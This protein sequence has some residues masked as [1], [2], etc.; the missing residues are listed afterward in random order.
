MIKFDVVGLFELV[1][2]DNETVYPLVVNLAY[3]WSSARKESDV[4]PQEDLFSQPLGRLLVHIECF[5]L[6]SPVD[7]L[8]IV[9]FALCLEDGDDDIG[10]CV[11]AADYQRLDADIF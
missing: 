8:D 10:S 5:R 4:A 9:H 2:P 11:A 6:V 1:D 3:A 7:R